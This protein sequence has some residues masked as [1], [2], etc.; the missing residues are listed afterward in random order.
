MSDWLTEDH[1]R[2]IS[3]FLICNWLEKNKRVLGREKKEEA[4]AVLKDVASAHCTPVLPFYGTCFQFSDPGMLVW[5][6]LT[7]ESKIKS[8]QEQTVHSVGINLKLLLLNAYYTIWGICSE[9]KVPGHGKYLFKKKCCGEKKAY[10]IQW[11]LIKNNPYVLIGF[12]VEDRMPI[13]LFRYFFSQTTETTP[14]EE[15]VKISLIQINKFPFLYSY[16]SFSSPVI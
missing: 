3:T 1:N 8:S 14:K 16:L 4:A 15:V 11:E 13:L 6:R 2:Y 9:C 10:L 5:L 12:K 7:C